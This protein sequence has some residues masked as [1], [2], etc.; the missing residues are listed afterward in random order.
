MSCET[1]TKLVF[2]VY[3]LFYPKL[4]GTFYYN[5]VSEYGYFTCGLA[6][7]QQSRI[8]NKTFD[9]I[10]SPRQRVSGGFGAKLGQFPSFVNMNINKVLNNVTCSGVLISRRHVLTAGHCFSTEEFNVRLPTNMMTATISPTIYPVE[11]W[12]KFN[13]RRYNVAKICKSR[14]YKNKD[15]QAIHDV[16]LLRLSDDVDFND[17]VRPA[18]LP[19]RRITRS[20]KCFSLGTGW[21]EGNNYPHIRKADV[22]QVLPVRYTPCMFDKQ[23]DASRICFKA[24]IRMFRGD[25][26]FGDSGGPTLCSI[27]AT[28]GGT[29][30]RWEV[31]GLTSYGKNVCKSGLANPSVNYD[32]YRQAGEIL[33]LMKGC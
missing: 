24:N 1:L 7:S 22:L 12:D 23:E 33:E 13:V 10:S 27:R 25:T 8:A 11:R 2:I 18:C 6:A 4:I 19:S 17:V 5:S 14:R 9:Q 26:C 31:H 28:K 15:G 3:F 16:T 29:K 32:T 20:D 21:L 30:F